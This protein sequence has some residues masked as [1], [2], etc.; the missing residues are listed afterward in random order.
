MSK[1]IAV[2]IPIILCVILALLGALWAALMRVGWQLPPL[3][4]PLA[5]QHGALMISG[6]LGTLVS[7]ERAV[8]LQRKWA[9][10]APL[11]AGIGGVTLLIGL[12]PEIGRGLITL[13][14]IGLVLIFAFI[15]RLHPT[16]DVITM[17]LGSV[18]WLTGNLLWLVGPSI[19]YAVPWWAGFLILTIA[20][21]RI[22]L[23]RVLMLKP[24]SRTIFK[25]AVAVFSMGLAL[26]LA[27]FDGGLK[28]SGLGLIMLGAWLLRYDITRYTIKKTGLT[29]YIAACLLP[30]YVWLIVGG[31][32]WI[33]YG[34]N[35]FAGLTYDALLHTLFLGFVFSMIFGHAPIIVPAVMPIDIK[36]H[37]RFYIPLVLLQ[38]SLMVRVFADLTL[39]QPLRMWAGLFNVLAILIFLG[40]LIFSARRRR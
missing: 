31:V 35:V 18:M 3:P 38:S 21:E 34:G 2:R 32:L 10:A 30:G 6:F 15:Y 37:W 9:Y 36:Y 33:G 11:L 29:R 22:E 27:A 20:G 12:P 24:I 23:S 17:T 19:V 1:T 16:I 8:A 25:I 26:S 5:G 40:N 28:L 13:G 4:V 7:L 14:S 39:N